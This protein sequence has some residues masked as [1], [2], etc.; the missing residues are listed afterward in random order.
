[1]SKSLKNFLTIRDVLSIYPAEL[2]RCF[3][4]MSHYRS[5]I[6]YSDVSV[7]QTKGALDRLYNSLRELKLVKFKLDELNLNPVIKEYYN[8]FITVMDD[9][10]NAPEG[11]SVLFEI[12]KEINKQKDYDIEQAGQLGFLLK[13]LANIFGV[14]QQDPEQY[15]KQAEA[16]YK[17]MSNSLSDA[18]IEG[19]IKQRE[20]ARIDKDYKKSDEIRISY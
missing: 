15:F 11:F 17:E 10:F 4:V 20:Q 3:L 5:E 7:K 2:I 14:L 13:T 16:P 19:L 18:E 12:A 8:K 9:D 6:H 1:M